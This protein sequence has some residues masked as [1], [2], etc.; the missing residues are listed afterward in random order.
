LQD[1]LDRSREQNL[2]EDEVL[3]LDGYEQLDQ[4][5]QMLKIRAYSVV[6]PAVAG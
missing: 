4:L 5:M 6:H 3:E 1:L 2:S